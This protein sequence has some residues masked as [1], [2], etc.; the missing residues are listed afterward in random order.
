[1][2]LSQII[3]IKQQL[4]EN[5]DALVTALKGIINNPANLS[6]DKAHI[7]AKVIVMWGIIKNDAGQLQ[8]ALTYDMVCTIVGKVLTTFDSHSNLSTGMVAIADNVFGNPKNIAKMRRYI[9]KLSQQMD[10][11]INYRTQ[12]MNIA[13]QLLHKNEDPQ[14]KQQLLSL[15]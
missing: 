7:V 9:V 4:S 5:G 15:V 13:N 11:K 3:D 8:S 1:M 14:V 12:T 6:E 10:S 2:K